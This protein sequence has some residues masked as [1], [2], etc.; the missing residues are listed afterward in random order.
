VVPQG[1]PCVMFRTYNAG[2]QLHPPPITRCYHKNSKGLD[3]SV[4]SRCKATRGLACETRSASRAQ[5]WMVPRAER[6]R[7]GKI[8]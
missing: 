3:C 7:W 8:V 4:Q 1:H 2:V 6:R 5:R